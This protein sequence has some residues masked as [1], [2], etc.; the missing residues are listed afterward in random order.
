MSLGLH[1]ADFSGP[2]LAF[3]APDLRTLA[4]EFDRLGIEVEDSRLDDG[5]LHEL[6]FRDPDGHGVRL[7]EART[8]SPPALEHTHESRL[9]YFDEYALGSADP[10]AT[11]RFWEQLG[12]VAFADDGPTPRKVVAS[13]RDINLALH[14]ADLPAP[15]LCFAAADLPQ[16]IDSLR[17]LGC[18]FAQRLPRGLAALG[19]ALLVAPDGL[20]ILLLESAA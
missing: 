13:H 19:G 18:S 1:R 14:D 17:K 6:T 16:R 4:G 7:L 3:T 20:Q 11:G 10:V 15:A 9:G 8:F 2:L 12:F 5:S